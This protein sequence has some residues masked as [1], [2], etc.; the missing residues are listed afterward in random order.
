MH[1]H[2]PLRLLR[3]MAQLPL[4]FTGLDAAVF[5]QIAVIIAIK[6]FQGLLHGAVAQEHRFALQ[7][8]V[9]P[10]S[11]PHRDR[12]YVYGVL[13]RFRSKRWAWSQTWDANSNMIASGRSGMG[14]LR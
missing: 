11:L 14:F 8:L 4:L 1:P 3:R 12:R 10:L 5:D 2:R 13:D 6:G 7:A 9:A